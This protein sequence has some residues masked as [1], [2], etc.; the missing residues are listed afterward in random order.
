ML[1]ESFLNKCWR[2][3]LVAT[4]QLEWISEVLDTSCRSSSS[5]SKTVISLGSSSEGSSRGFEDW[6][7]IDGEP[8]TMA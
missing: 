6:L 7:I 5:R 1:L 8:R 2:L 4:S 3:S